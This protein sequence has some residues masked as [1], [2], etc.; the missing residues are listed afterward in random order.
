M[1]FIK[2]YY[3]DK[4]Y[5]FY[6]D[7]AVSVAASKKEMVLDII[8]YEFQRFCATDIEKMKTLLN[9]LNENLICHTESQVFKGIFH[10]LENPVLQGFVGFEL[11]DEDEYDCVL[12]TI[13]LD[14]NLLYNDDFELPIIS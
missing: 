8:K 12:V 3:E 5:Y 7:E 13:H 4:E 10:M 11:N 2:F 14:S 1:Y 9:I 6:F